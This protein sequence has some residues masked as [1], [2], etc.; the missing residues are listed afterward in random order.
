MHTP[1]EEL[2]DENGPLEAHRVGSLTTERIRQILSERSVRFVVANVGSPLEWH[3]GDELYSFWANAK[4]HICDEP[5]GCK[6]ED[7][8]D[9][10]FYL[11][12]EWQAKDE[13]IILLISSH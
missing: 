10:Y 13:T 6:L 5:N 9:G 12:E 8:S 3:C 1:I 11:A 4:K 2:W 7:F